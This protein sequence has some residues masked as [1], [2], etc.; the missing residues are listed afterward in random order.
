M[1]D[2]NAAI[3]EEFRAN[4]GRVEQ[5]GEA[6][7]VILHTIGAKSGAVREI[8]LVTMHSDGETF[9]FASA[10]GSPQHPDWYHNLKATPEI[11]VETG[12]ETYR[13]RLTPL[14]EAERA[15]RLAQQAERIPT[16]GDYIINA[17]PRLIPVFR[18]DRL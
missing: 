8:P 7:L 12:T 6:E 10:G 1:T 4:D 5:F 16:F 2:W 13:A 9:V 11:E 3:I 15:R 18:I 14:D 17:E